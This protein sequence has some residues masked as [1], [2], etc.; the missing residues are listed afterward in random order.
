MLKGMELVKVIQ[1]DLASK[2][3]FIYPVKE[4]R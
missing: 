3:V 4:N 2:E 1:R